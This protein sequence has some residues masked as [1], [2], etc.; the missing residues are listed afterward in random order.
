M[1]GNIEN[2]A[3]RSIGRLALFIIALSG[4]GFTFAQQTPAGDDW[5]EVVVEEDGESEFSGLSGIIVERDPKLEPKPKV[6][7]PVKM[8]VAGLLDEVDAVGLE[9]DLWSDAIKGTDARKSHVGT[10]YAVAVRSGVSQSGFVESTKDL[11]SNFSGDS[12]ELTFIVP[13]YQVEERP[14][15]ELWTEGDCQLSIYKTNN[16]QVGIPHNCATEAYT[17]PYTG[18]ILRAMMACVWPGTDPEKAAVEFKRPGLE[19]INPSTGGLAESDR[20]TAAQEAG[21]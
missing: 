21:E 20:S 16:T 17:P 13:F 11:H 19:S 8:L 10:G 6:R 7:V 5:K 9:C 15:I 12:I 1:P 4:T 2:P 3:V 18:Q 14:P